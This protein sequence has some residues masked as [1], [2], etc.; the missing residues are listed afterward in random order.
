[1]IKLRQSVLRSALIGA[2]GLCLATSASAQDTHHSVGRGSIWGAMLGVRGKTR[3]D[4]AILTQN[5]GFDPHSFPGIS[6]KRD[7]RNLWGF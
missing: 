4:T 2:A 5:S 1:M 7:R 3:R 6:T